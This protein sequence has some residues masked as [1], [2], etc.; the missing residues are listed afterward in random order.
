MSRI[1]DNQLGIINWED[2][3]KATKSILQSTGAQIDK[4]K[5]NGK[6]KFLSEDGEYEIDASVEFT[7]LGG[8]RFF[9]LVECRAKKAGNKIKR[10]EVLAFHSKI[11]SLKAQKGIF[12]TTSGYQRGAVEYAKKHSIAL[13]Q[14]VD[15]K[16]TYITKGMDNVPPPKW[17]NLPEYAGWLVD[18]SG[19]N[20]SYSLVRSEIGEE[21]LTP[22]IT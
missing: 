7:M 6:K 1:N 13:I 4:F 11:H 17:L 20:L 16:S 8:A 22:Q 2:F 10:D 3:E 18:L 21:L 5:V 14:V 15:G 19:N 9:V 12:F